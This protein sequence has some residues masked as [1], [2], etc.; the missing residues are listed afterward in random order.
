MRKSPCTMEARP[1]RAPSGM[2]SGSHSMRRSIDS[3]GSVTEAAYC[4][5]QRPIWRS[6]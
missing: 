5:L 2:C 3:I 4:L 6:K 1:S